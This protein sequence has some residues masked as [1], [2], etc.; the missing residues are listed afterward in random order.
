MLN[1]LNIT[2]IL[3]RIIYNNIKSLLVASV[4]TKSLPEYTIP[5]FGIKIIKLLLFIF[6]KT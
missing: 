5:K 6:F 4:I 1:Q 3:S 2:P